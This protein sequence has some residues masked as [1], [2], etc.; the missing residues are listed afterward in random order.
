MKSLFCA[1]GSED[2]DLSDE[3]LKREIESFLEAL[4]KREDVLILPPDYTRYHSQAGKITQMIAEHYHFIGS[5]SVSSPEIQIMPALGTHAPM[6]AEQIE[7]MFGKE[8]ASKDP[9]P[10]LVHDWRNDV[11]TIGH[12]PAKMV[13]CGGNSRHC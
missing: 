1:I 8:L 12:A 2:F 13:S 5:D 6:S 11:V 9:N 7:G 10:F 4:G 3:A